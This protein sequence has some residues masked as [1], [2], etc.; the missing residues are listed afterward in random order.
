MSVDSRRRQHA[1][2]S[3]RWPSRA[4]SSAAST[5]C[6]AE[7][8]ELLRPYLFAA[9]DYPRPTSSPRCTR[10]A[11]RAERCCTCPKGVVIDQPLHMLSALSRRRRRSGPHAGR[12]RRRRR[13]DAAGRNRQPPTASRPPACTAGRSSCWSAPAP[14]CATSTCRTGAPACGISPISGRWSIATPRCNG[15]SAPWAA[16][17]PR[18]ISTWPWSGPAPTRRSTA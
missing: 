11:G 9:V 6:S 3:A 4:C 16:G 13:G 14:G 7:H 10:P 5:G 2:R 17:W 1:P 15:P 12:A 18:S 8:G